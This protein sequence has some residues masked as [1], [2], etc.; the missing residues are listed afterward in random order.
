M[1]VYLLL[2]L[3]FKYKL[4][5]TH[6]FYICFFFKQNKSFIDNAESRIATYDNINDYIEP[7]H[8]DLMLTYSWA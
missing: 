8:L 4:L 6:T 1:D 3:F 2:L 7:L 5:I